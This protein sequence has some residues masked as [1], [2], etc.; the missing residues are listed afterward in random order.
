MSGTWSLLMPGLGQLYIHRIFM[1]IFIFVWSVI[2]FY[3][4]HLLEAISFLFVGKIAEA[5][6]VLKEEWL[7]FFPSVYGCVFYD[8]YLHTVENNKLYENEQRE[9]LKTHFQDPDFNIIKGDKMQLYSIFESNIYIEKAIIMLQ[10][11]GIAKTDIYAMSLEDVKKERLFFDTLHNSDGYSMFD[12]AA[13][14]ATVFA[15]VSSSIGFM[16]KWG[17][18]YWGLIGAFAGLV[19]GTLIKFFY[20]KLTGKKLHKISKRKPAILLIIRCSDKKAQI[21]QSILIKNNA[22]GIAKMNN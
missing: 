16:L 11:E 2:F 8:C 14:L 22:L 13:V 6:A 18:I 4:S 10:N 12:L 9:Y 15:V 7:L 20:I 1:A 17:P 19:F 21:V 5:T 3:Y